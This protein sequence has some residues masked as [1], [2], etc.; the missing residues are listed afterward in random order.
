MG[1]SSRPSPSISTFT[2]STATV[3][4]PATYPTVPATYA[5]R[6]SVENATREKC[7]RYAVLP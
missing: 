2:D 3:P 7:D 1:T 6:P 5:R 4:S